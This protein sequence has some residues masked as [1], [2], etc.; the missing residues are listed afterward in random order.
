M[1]IYSAIRN[2]ITTFKNFKDGSF[3]SSWHLIKNWYNISTSMEDRATLGSDPSA[4]AGG[5]TE[6]VHCARPFYIIYNNASGS[7]KSDKSQR[8]W[9]TAF[10][11]IINNQ[12]LKL[13]LLNHDLV[14]IFMLIILFN[15]NLIILIKSFLTFE[16]ERFPSD[17]SSISKSSP[18]GTARLY[19]FL[20]KLSAKFT[21]R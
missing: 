5:Y 14:N 17:G 4:T 1:K 19:Y 15:Y 8:V 10:P 20:C 18:C 21:C 2:L 16:H 9:G 11:N 3:F 7:H 12:Y 13:N 6:A